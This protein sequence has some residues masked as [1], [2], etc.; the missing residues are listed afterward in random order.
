MERN[1]NGM[2]RGRTNSDSSQNLG[3]LDG[4][5]GDRSGGCRGTQNGVGESD[6]CLDSLPLAYAYVP[7]QRWRMLYPHEEAL[8]RGTLFEEL[9]K[10]L[11]VYGNE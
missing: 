4:F 2:P 6:A 9:D 8:H 5:F 7:W 10:P 1:E 11:G 3:A